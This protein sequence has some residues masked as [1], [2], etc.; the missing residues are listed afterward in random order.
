MVT[1]KKN[2][3]SALQKTW[4]IVSYSSGYG[5]GGGVTQ[6]FTLYYMSFLTFAMGLNPLAAGAVVAVGK[7]W[8]GFVDPM[9][10]LI[11]DRTH[12]K[13]GSCRPWFLAAAIPVFITYFMLWYPFGISGETGRF[14]YFLAAQI[15]FSTAFSM[16]MVPYEAILPKITDSYGERTN[17]SSVRMV[18]S[19][20]FSVGGNYVY[21]LLIPAETAAEYAGMSGNFFKLGLILGAVFAIPLLVTFAGTKEKIPPLQTLE[22]P[23]ETL[24]SVFKTY[25]ELLRCKLF[26]KCFLL[27]VLG[28]FIYYAVSV[29]L[30]TFVLLVYTNTAYE[31]SFWTFSF[32]M[33][34]SFL[35]VNIRDA[36]E[37]SFFIPNVLMMKKRNKHRPFLVDLPLLAIGSLI[38]FF[39]TPDAGI[40]FYFIAVA[41]IGAGVSCLNFVPNS[42]M[43]DLADVDELVS[44]IRREGANAGLVSL[45][46]Q[47]AQGAAFLVCGAALFA[48]GLSDETAA[49]PEKATALS[50]ASLK[51][52]LCVIPVIGGA[53][54]FAISKT[55][56]LT[57]ET[58]ALIKTKIQEKRTAGQTAL[59]PSDKHTFSS[60]TGLPAD[61]LWISK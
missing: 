23:K 41:F 51:I 56:G 18:F 45:G 42:L 24:K 43:P 16:G 4:K 57:P 39:I 46:R 44:G 59:S 25:G 35:V 3:K 53:V 49:T 36:F 40:I 52:M 34:L 38:V 58:H 2:F 14:F 60:V 28:S 11:V 26:K 61:D 20:L 7:I 47:V 37:M 12:T 54:M 19:G 48:F 21:Q 8:D 29:S 17:Y 1:E 31:I 6:V 9:M 15:L 50:L 55:Y 10:G 33:T 5:L 27:T 32:S 22:K 30:V 13:L